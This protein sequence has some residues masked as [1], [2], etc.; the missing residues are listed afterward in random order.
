M[1]TFVAIEISNNQVIESIKKFQSEI[2][3]NAKPVEPTNFHFTLQFLG[4][5]SEDVSKKSLM[6]FVL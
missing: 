5:I 1:R 6:L 2:K 4:E 3:I